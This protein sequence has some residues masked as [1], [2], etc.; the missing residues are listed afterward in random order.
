MLIFNGDGA[1]AHAIFQQ[2]S[3]LNLF[4]R[5]MISSHLTTVRII[6]IA[7]LSCHR[8]RLSQVQAI[9]LHHLPNQVNVLSLF[10]HCTYPQSSITIHHQIYSCVF[11]VDDDVENV[12]KDDGEDEDGTSGSNQQVASQ[13]QFIQTL[14]VTNHCHD[15]LVIIIPVVALS[16]GEEDED[17]EGDVNMYLSFVQHVSGWKSCHF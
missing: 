17:G 13:G 6:E 8:T 3:R 2:N 1:F 5:P 12:D 11:S 9:S 16:D 15:S 7:H 10:S 14:L 4:S